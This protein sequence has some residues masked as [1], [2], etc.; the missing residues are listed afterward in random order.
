ML[1]VKECLFENTMLSL[2]VIFA[3]PKLSSPDSQKATKVDSPRYFPFVFSTPLR[4]RIE[5]YN[6]AV[7]M[8]CVF[9][10]GIE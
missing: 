10:N 1:L 2:E 3:I 6:Q 8:A 9:H 5:D 4:L 7:K